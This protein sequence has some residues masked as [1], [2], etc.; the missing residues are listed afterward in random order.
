MQENSQA[1]ARRHQLGDV[2]DRMAW[3][4]ESLARLD[5]ARPTREWMKNLANRLIDKK[6]KPPLG[7]LEK[8]RKVALI[9][10]FAENCQEIMIPRPFVLV[11]PQIL[12]PNPTTSTFDGPFEEKDPC[13]QLDLSDSPDT[14][15]DE[16]I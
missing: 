16:F 8:R 9:C 5:E 13:P 4:L 14:N 11:R 7:R 12:T 2:Y 15:E 6:N 3:S 10:W 1:S